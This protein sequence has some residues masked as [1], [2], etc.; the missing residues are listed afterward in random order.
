[1]IDTTARRWLCWVALVV[2]SAGC[3]GTALDV[4]DYGGVP[5]WST[6]ALPEARGELRTQPDGKRVAVR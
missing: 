3:T 5:K 4:P 2:A 6:R 1:M